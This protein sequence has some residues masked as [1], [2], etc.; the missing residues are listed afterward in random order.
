[1]GHR[2][3]LVY[4]FHGCRKSVAEVLLSGRD[5]M[6]SIDNDYDSLGSGIYLG[7][8]HQRGHSN[9]LAGNLEEMRQSL[10]RRFDL[11]VV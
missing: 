11:G 4:G 1:M 2:L 6:L 9:G 5:V 10:V 7:K 8:K 3:E